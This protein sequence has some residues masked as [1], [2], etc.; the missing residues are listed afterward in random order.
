MFPN[1]NLLKP[2]VKRPQL[3]ASL[4]TP[5]KRRSVLRG[6]SRQRCPFCKSMLIMNGNKCSVC[7]STVPNYWLIKDSPMWKK[8]YKNLGLK[9]YDDGYDGEFL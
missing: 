5:Q 9:G 4:P 3:D 7:G 8:I 6:A 2:I 1:P